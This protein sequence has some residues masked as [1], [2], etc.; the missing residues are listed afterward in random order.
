M[1]DPGENYLKLYSEWAIGLATF[2]GGPLAAGILIR[3]NCINLGREKQGFNALMIGILTTFLIIVLLFAL[4][5]ATIDKIPSSLLPFVYTGIIFFIL[6]KIQGKDIRLH[7]ANNG[8]FY[9]GWRAAGIGAMSMAVYLSFIFIAVEI[10]TRSLDFE[11]AQYDSGIEQFIENENKA[12][13]VFQFLDSENTDLLIDDF[14]KG[15]V[16]WRENKII[17]DKLNTIENLPEELKDQNDILGRYSELRI[18]QYQLIIKA[19]KE[20]T[21]KYDAQID[22]IIKEIDRVTDELE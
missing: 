22:N 14:L 1:N 16:L 21:D 3:R 11:A 5:E 9:S 2:F 4:P 20:D 12:M 13:Q 10:D 19:L 6:E 17:V 18:T 7:K 8:E 15:I